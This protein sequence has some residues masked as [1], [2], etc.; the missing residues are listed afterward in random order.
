M[1][2]RVRRVRRPVSAKEFIAY[3]PSLRKWIHLPLHSLLGVHAKDVCF[4][5]N[6]WDFLSPSSFLLTGGNGG[7][8][9]AIVKRP[10]IG[11]KHR[12]TY[13]TYG[14]NRHRTYLFPASHATIVVFY[15][16]THQARTLPALPPSFSMPSASSST[17]RRQTRGN[18]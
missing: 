8:L 14:S 12:R 6:H 4:C 3:I 5:V 11:F 9:C 7:L 17:T 18:M 16:L 13:P 10:C 15:P 2:M 1:G